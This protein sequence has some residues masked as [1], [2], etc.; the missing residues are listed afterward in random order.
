MS[1]LFDSGADGVTTTSERNTR[2]RLLREAM[3]LFLRDGYDSVA[4]RQVCLAAGV[5]QP[6]LY[7]HFGSKEGLYFAVIAQ[8]FSDLRDAI[9]RATADGE[10]FRNRLLNLALIFWSGE[11][12]EYQ[13][14]QRDAMRHMPRA[15]IPALRHIIL[16]SVIS[17]LLELMSAGIASGDL[18]TYA[19][20]Y[21]LMELF[22]AM[23]DG[24]AGLY[25]RGDALPTP[26][27]NTAPIEMFIAGAHAISAETYAA[28]PQLAHVEALQ[29][30]AG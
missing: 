26:A 21:A 2:Q 5:T 16:D 8:W 15:R 9:T 28:W 20:P 12:G 19:E 25:H 14:M 7:H 3:R 10:T 23:V 6:S 29:R 18:P 24:F 1:D 11:A 17:P 22:W 27:R 30:D 4:T 13:A